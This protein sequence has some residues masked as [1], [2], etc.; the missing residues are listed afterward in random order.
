MEERQ[1]PRY[2]MIP[3]QTTAYAVAKDLRLFASF[4][5]SLNPGVSWLG[6]HWNETPTTASSANVRERR[7]FG[8]ECV[9]GGVDERLVQE[10]MP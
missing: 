5:T 3:N 2:T 10:A 4:E 1:R 8:R 9:I 6:P 7:H